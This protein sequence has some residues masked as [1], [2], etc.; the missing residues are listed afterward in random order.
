MLGQL[1]AAPADDGAQILLLQ[2]AADAV[3]VEGAPVHHQTF[4]IAGR[5]SAQ[6]LVLRALDHP[7]QRLVRMSITLGG[8]PLMLGQAARR[9]RLGAPDRLLLVP[10][11]IHQRRALVERE[12]DV[13]A[14]LMLDLQRHLGREAVLGPVEMRRERHPVVV[15]VGQSLLALGDHVV[16][17]QAGGVHREHLL[18]ADAERQHLESP[19]VGEGRARPV[20]EAT[21]PAGR[22]HDVRPGLQVQVVGVGQQRLRPELRPCSPAAPPSPSPWCRRR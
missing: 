18:E 13:A 4:E 20:H 11:G 5:L 22:V 19:A 17:A 15:D 16:V 14:Q 1:L 12:H 10:A 7:E 21:E 6:V 2:G 9:P 3:A 8:E